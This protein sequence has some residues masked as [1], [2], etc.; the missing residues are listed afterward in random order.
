MKATPVGVAQ[1][2]VLDAL[3][4]TAEDFFAANQ[5]FENVGIVVTSKRVG[6]SSEP[7]VRLLETHFAVFN[8]D[9]EGEEWNKCFQ[10]ID[11]TPVAQW[12]VE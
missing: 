12:I 6:R 1:R 9:G 11:L 8:Q 10:P 7:V 2:K 5:V 4:L 3:N